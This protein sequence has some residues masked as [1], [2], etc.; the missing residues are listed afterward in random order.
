MGEVIGFRQHK[1]ET[2]EAIEAL[3]VSV[4]Y[5]LD[6]DGR[7]RMVIACADQD[8]HAFLSMAATALMAE[9]MKATGSLLGPEDVEYE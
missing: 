5:G 3:A 6:A 2:T 8:M 1:S 9:A 4:T 7:P